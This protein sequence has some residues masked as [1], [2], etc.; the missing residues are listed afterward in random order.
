MHSIL[1]AITSYFPSTLGQQTTGCADPSSLCPI[2]HQ[3]TAMD[4]PRGVSCHTNPPESITD[5][6][7]FGIRGCI[8]YGYPSTGGVL[9]KGPID[10]VDITFL[11]LPR[12]HVAQR[13]PSAEEEDRF[14]NLLRRLGATWWP[15]KEE[16][17][18]VNMGSREKTEEE[19]KVLVQDHDKTRDRSK[20]RTRTRLYSMF[21]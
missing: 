17:I 5:R 12:F 3:Q 16:Y 11:S 6:T 19:E 10:L 1:V 20:I 4:N 21:V 13:S 7:R 18:M 8:V 9:I 14:C 15:S 2:P